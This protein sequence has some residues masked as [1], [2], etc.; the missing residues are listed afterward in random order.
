MVT[1]KSNGVIPYDEFKK[2]LMDEL[3]ATWPEKSF[4]VRKVRNSKGEYEGLREVLAPDELNIAV[5]ILNLELLYNEYCQAIETEKTRIF[6]D[7]KE[8]I[9]QKHSVDLEE[10]L[11]RDYLLEHVWLRLIDTK[12]LQT[13]LQDVPHREFLDLSWF[14]YTK[15]ILE[16]GQGYVNITEDLL[17]KVAM[18]ED[19]LFN[20]AMKNTLNKEF[21][22]SLPSQILF[23]I[24]L[25]FPL[26]SGEYGASCILDDEAVQAAFEKAKGDFI[27]LPSSIHEWMVLPVSEITAIT[28]DRSLS[29]LREIVRI[30]NQ[31]S[32]AIQEKDI[33]SNNIY[34]YSKSLD[35]IAMILLEDETVEDV[36]ERNEFQNVKKSVLG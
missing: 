36:Y 7:A 23:S 15:I 31:D 24:T 8:I 33:L 3:R 13:L 19:E 4:M 11:T 26:T 12:K 2:Q 6:S 34:L 28:A 30:I 17:K 10:Y 27:L 35:G 18:T 16:E 21:T 20:A 14:C 25:P 22:M 32:E 9:S 5:P 1:T 29:D